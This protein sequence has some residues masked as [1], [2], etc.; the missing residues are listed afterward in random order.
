MPEEEPLGLPQ[1]VTV[2]QTQPDDKDE[3]M[4]WE[5]LGNEGI[6]MDFDSVMFPLISGDI[7]ERVYINMDS[8]VLK[9]YKAKIRSIEQHTVADRRY[10]S[11]VYF[12]TLFLYTIS[13]KRGYEIS[14]RTDDDEIRDVG[15]TDYLIDMFSSHYAAFLLNFGMSELVEALG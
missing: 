8:G 6:E 15:L 5:K 11:S 14:R 13:K 2:Y 1:V 9:D 10:I 7:L 12:H 3:V 4:T